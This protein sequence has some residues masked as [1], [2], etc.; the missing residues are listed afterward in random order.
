MIFRPWTVSWPGQMTWPLPR[1][2]ESDHIFRKLYQCGTSICDFH[3][4]PGATH[5]TK[6][7]N[8]TRQNR[9][10]L[11]PAPRCNIHSVCRIRLLRMDWMVPGKVVRIYRELTRWGCRPA[12]MSPDRLL[13]GRLRTSHKVSAPA[14]ITGLFAGVMNGEGR[15]PPPVTAIQAPLRDCTGAGTGY[16]PLG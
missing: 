14:A 4:T 13:T 7:T 1:R 9:R 12:G 15:L 3:R 11:A 8:A 10:A 5:L 6:T 2:T 16:S